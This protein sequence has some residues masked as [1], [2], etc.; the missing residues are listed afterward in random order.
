MIGQV[1]GRLVRGFV[2]YRAVF[3]NDAIEEIDLRTYLQQLFELPPG[4]MISRR[5]EAFSFFRAATVDRLIPPSWQVFHH[6]RRLGRG[7]RANNP[8]MLLQFFVSRGIGTASKRCLFLTGFIPDYSYTRQVTCRHQ[9]YVRFSVFD[10]S[11][12]W[13]VRGI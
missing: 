2:D 6:I 10:E 1:P 7:S 9:D 3:R 12:D 13:R 8:L 5:P 11:R 4:N